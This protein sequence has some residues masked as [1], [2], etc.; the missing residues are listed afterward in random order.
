M[1]DAKFTPRI[2]ETARGLWGVYFVLSM[3]CLLSY[4]WGGMSWADAFMHM[5]TTVGLG[6]LSSH[7][8]SFAYWNSPTL[9]W[10]AILFMLL[11]GI[12]FARY[13]VLWRQRSVG[14]L[15]RDAEVRAYIAVMGTC[16]LITHFVLQSTETIVSPGEAFRTAAF[17]VVSVAT[18][19]GFTTVDYA[20]WPSFLPVLLLLLGSFVSCA[21]STGGGIK[22]IRMLVLVQVARRELAR[23]LHPRA[24]LPLN[25]GN[26]PVPEDVV[27]A[28]MAFM[29]IYCSTIV[30]LALVLLASGLDMVT[31]FTAVL[32]M[33]SNV[34][35]GLGQVGP[36][37][38]FSVLNDFQIWVCSLGMLLGRLEMM[39]V[40][41]L[42][43]PRFWRR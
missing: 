30:L 37:G 8:Q 18:T 29:L 25:L 42:F 13:F 32:G 28:V 3:A 17:Q 6:G 9:E 27:W 38:N 14:I 15:T 22:M 40:L 43:T 12:S 34:G 23:I 31:A 21:G 1:K 4:R 39:S 20:L 11:S 24:V 19:T 41:V 33:V 10:L 2:A 5:C 35:P 36:A 26:R 16:I 7:D